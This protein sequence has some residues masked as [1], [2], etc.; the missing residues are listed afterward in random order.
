MTDT[1]KKA[2][3]EGRPA[4]EPK[5]NPYRRRRHEAKFSKTP[6]SAYFFYFGPAPKGKEARRF[7]RYYYVSHHRP[8]KRKHLRDLITHLA[9]N[10]RLDRSEQYPVPHPTPTSQSEWKRKSYLIALVDDPGFRFTPDE[11][12]YFDTSRKGLPNH[13]FFDAKDFD[14]IELPALDKPGEKQK[15]SAVCVINH[16]KRVDEGDLLKSD[17]PQF[18]AIR[19]CPSPMGIRPARE[20][21]GGKN[22]GPPVPPP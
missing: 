21:D 18:F 19:F 22:V 20:D 10:A 8:I 13:T 16:M 5:C 14:D 3:G 15:V 2:A 12:F 6:W 17:D 11:A 1:P 7:D 4:D 9:L